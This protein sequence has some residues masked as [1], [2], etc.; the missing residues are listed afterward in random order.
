[1]IWIHQS[2]APKMTQSANL[3]FNYGQASQRSAPGLYGLGEETTKE[4]APD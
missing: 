2:A 3:R 1:M 4:C